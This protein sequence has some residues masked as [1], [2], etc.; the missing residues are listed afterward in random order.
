MAQHVKIIAILS[1]ILGAAMALLG[2]IVFAIIAGAGAVSGEEDAMVVTGIVG[3]AVGG[4][5]LLLSLPAIIG[6]VGL[7]KNRGWARILILIVGGLS[8]LNFPFGTAYGV[9]AIVVLMHDEVRPL[10]A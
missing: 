5:F 3:T 7:M 4:I 9:Y 8:L 10:F 1:I 2:F 6:G